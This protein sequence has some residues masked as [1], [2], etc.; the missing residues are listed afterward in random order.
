MIWDQFQ[1][2]TMI[3]FKHLPTFCPGKNFRGC[4]WSL[5]SCIHKEQCVIHLRREG[6][7]ESNWKAYLL[8]RILISLHLHSIG[9]S[10]DIHLIKL[11]NKNIWKM[12][13][14]VPAF[15]FPVQF[16]GF[17]QHF[18]IKYVNFTIVLK[19]LMFSNLTLFTTA[20]VLEMG[21]SMSF[22]K[23]LKQFSRQLK[24]W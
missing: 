7:V 21:P 3:Y 24:F 16:S 11:Q 20:E 17:A 22:M 8:S 6:F 9:Y 10:A 13:Q 19:E 2:F 15:L 12:C 18:L 5:S 1:V 14:P 23:Y 4:V